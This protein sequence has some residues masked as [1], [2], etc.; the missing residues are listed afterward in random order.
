MMDHTNDYGAILKKPACRCWDLKAPQ[1]SERSWNGKDMFAWTF[2]SDKNGK[3]EKW[4]NVGSSS[5][6]HL[7][8][9]H[10]RD[11]LV[12]FARCMVVSN[13]HLD[14][15]QCTRC[16][17]DTS[18]PVVS[19]VTNQHLPNLEWIPFNKV[20]ASFSC[21]LLKLRRPMKKTI[22]VIL[23]QHWHSET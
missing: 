12:L 3:V 2:K 11:L 8:E 13:S 16:M 5:S 6:L 15:Q 20:L 4:S 17:A 22:K 23:Q 19:Q 9:P 14:E 10:L 18:V 7:L 1:T 21:L